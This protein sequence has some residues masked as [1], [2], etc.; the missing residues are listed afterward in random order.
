MD[1]ERKNE[2]K[3]GINAWEVISL[4]GRGVAKGVQWIG[5]APDNISNM[6]HD[7]VHT[8]RN[9]MSITE[10]VSIFNT[11]DKDITMINHETGQ[12]NQIIPALS[13]KQTRTAQTDGIWIPWY[14]PPR[15]ADFAHR[16][17]EFRVED[18]PI[19]FIWQRGYYIYW[20]SRLNE[21]GLPERTY[22][23]AGV[24]DA[25]GRRA[26]VIR[27]DPDFG[28]SAFLSHVDADR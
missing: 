27:Y 3:G 11:T 5:N 4:F 17:I 8:V 9:A 1:E 12:D 23:I 15:M 28:Y 19:L 26:M 7:G 18:R 16:C 13:M 21:N 14:D 2:S 25:V 22:K 20:C 6:I 10:I 24:A